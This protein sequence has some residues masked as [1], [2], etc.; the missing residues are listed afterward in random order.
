MAMFSWSF[1][2][3]RCTRFFQKKW[4][5]HFFCLYFNFNTHFFTIEA[6]RSHCICFVPGYSQWGA[7]TSCPVPCI[8]SNLNSWI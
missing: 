8:C 3:Q 7:T 4:L 6:S 5:E 2:F 1:Y